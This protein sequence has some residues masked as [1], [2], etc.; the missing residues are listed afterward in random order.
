MR[1]AHRLSLVALAL[2]A[3]VILTGAYVT[4][5]EVVARLSQSSVKPNE[6]AHRLLGYALILCVIG[7]AIR[8]RS[9]PR[10]VR[11]LG[12]T[13]AGMLALAIASGWRGAPLSPG[14]GV[15]HALL[16]HLLFTVTAVIALVTSAHW[17]RPAELA[18]VRRPFLRPLALVTP[19]VVLAQITLGALYRHNLISFILHVAT[20]MVVA[21]L[22]L[23]LSSVVLQHYPRPASLRRAAATLIATVLVQVS[24]G[25]ASL[26]MLL[27][28]FIATGYFIAATIAHVTVGA[29]TLAASIFF[30][31]EVWRSSALIH[32]HETVRNI[33][34][35]N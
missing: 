11:V 6:R 15:L 33:E 35:G 21:L 19:L 9:H 22:A 4:S 12:W 24:L 17:N 10:L 32:G 5:L 31:L 7:L 20:A 13:G 30:A 25:I 23:I 16:A 3:V 1:S 2:A 18:D 26:V 14:G 8:V 27:L 29:A 28:N 34:V